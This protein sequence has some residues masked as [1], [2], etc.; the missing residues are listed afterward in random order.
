MLD[1]LEA[2]GSTKF[3]APEVAAAE[4]QSGTSADVFSYGI[5]LWQI[6][7]RATL[8]PLLRREDVAEKVKNGHR[9]KLVPAWPAAFKQLLAECWSYDPAGRPQMPQVHER[10]CKIYDA[11]NWSEA[12]LIYFS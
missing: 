9:P 7:S 4:Y 8:Y 10:L 6:A 11:R 1:P 3:M 12:R 2:N 5:T